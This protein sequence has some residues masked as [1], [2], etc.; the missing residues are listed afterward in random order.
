MCSLFTI[1]MLN[2]VCMVVAGMRGG[3]GFRWRWICVGDRGV[4]W[5]RFG[6]VVATVLD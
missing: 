1:S 3:G 2:F 4:F 6:W 5:V